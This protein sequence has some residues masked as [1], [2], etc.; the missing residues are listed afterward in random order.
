MENYY[1]YIIKSEK[2]GRY[3]IG[4]CSDVDTRLKYH[5]NGWSKYTKAGMPWTLCYFEKYDS[6]TEALKRE[7]SVKSKKSRKYIE[8]L[9]KNIIAG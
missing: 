6:K 7:K 9:F 5:N 2:N 8:C 1:F 4:S 3:Y